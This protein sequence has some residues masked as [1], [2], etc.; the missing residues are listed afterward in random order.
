VSDRRLTWRNHSRDQSCHPRAIEH[1][2][3]TRELVELVQ[4]AEREG[5]TV[6][7]VGAGHAWSDVA[8]TGGYLLETDRMSGLLELDDGAL[9]PRAEGDLPLV[10]VRGGTRIHELNRLLDDRN[11]ALRNMGGYDGQ[12]IAGAVSTSTHGSGIGFG[13]F[14][15][16]VRSLDLVAS[17]GRLVRVEPRDG[18]TDPEAFAALPGDERELVQDDEVFLAAVCGI[19]CMGIVDSLVLEVRSEFWL[20]ERRVVRTWEEVRGE[21]SGGVLGRHDRYELFLNPYARKAGGHEVL[22]T[23]RDEVPK[24]DPDS[25]SPGDGE[26]H[27]LIEMQASIPLVWL[28]LRLAARLAPSLLRTQFGRTLRR[29]EDENYTQVS[30]RVM[31]IGAA[32]KL[33]ALSSELGVPTEG[34]AHLRV[35]D[36]ILEIADECAR[37]RKLFHTS[38]I[39]LRFVAP[40]RAYASMMH[41]GATMMIELI[42]VSETRGGRDLLAE[43]ESRLGEEF[44]A[45]PHWGQYNV[46]GPDREHLEGLY[47]RWGAWLAAYERFNASGV[48]DSEFTDRIGI[49]RRR[50]A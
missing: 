27:P 16:V 12:A 35:V 10:R 45:R 8:L 6:R 33:P 3:H 13:P 22:V 49:S 17:G 26:R 23:T 38:P 40:S 36:S 4:R 2:S 39:A 42:L 20:R 48:F 1:P 37:T 32:N 9:R 11:L 21:L 43:Y 50:S 24:P 41:E 14:P 25:L 34:V 46:L 29:M 28:A 7:A 31:N 30:Y 44:G 18:F 15:D 47:R 19:G 5:T